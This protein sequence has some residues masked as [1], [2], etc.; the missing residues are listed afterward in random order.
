M[1][2]NVVVIGAGPYGL[3]TAAHLRRRGLNV[4]IFGSPMAS[5]SQSMPA[6]MLLKSP[7]SA[8]TLSS[9]VPGQTLHDY[10]REAGEPVLGEHDQ[11]PIEMFVRY[12]L[13]FVGQQDF[14]VEDVRVLTVDRHSDGFRIKT[15]AGEELRAGA[16][17]VASGLTGFAHLPEELARAVP[18]GPAALGPVSHT[19]HHTDLGRFAGR[20]VVVVGSGQSAQ[21]NAAL[22]H[23]AGAQVTLLAR[24]P[25]IGFGA[26]PTSGWH[27]QPDTPLGRA[28]SLYAVIRYANAVPF[29]PPATR[30][31]LVREVLGPLGAWW[32]RPR[33]EGVV[34]VLAGHRIT[35]AEV[36]EDGVVL[37]TRDHQEGTRKIEAD[38]VMAGTGYRVDLAAL[39]FLA[40]EL[41]SSLD[42]TG[43]FPRLSRTFGSSV[44]GLYFTG[45]PAAA[46]FGPVMRF[47]CGT[48]F[49]SPRV[50]AAVTAHCN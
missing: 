15:A 2:Q 31:L 47:V 14:D 43:G 29:L 37:T 10:S 39:D 4:R 32:L 33:V 12:G 48:E 3:S 1:S 8:S 26:S 18:D 45:L 22:L 44:P 30:L 49:A 50:A 36:A 6:G 17:V 38:H 40:P 7:P 25:R 19:S 46:T 20:R 5:W 41:R 23:E 28:W 35:E 27:W 16:V 9:P 24:T 34:P 21:E 13:W 42:R 11:V